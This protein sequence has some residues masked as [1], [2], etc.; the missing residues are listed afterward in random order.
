MLNLYIDYNFESANF[1]ILEDDS[2]TPSSRTKRQISDRVIGGRIV[3]GF[4]SVPNSFPWALFIRIF[5]TKV[6]EFTRKRMQ[7]KCGGSLLNKKFG[8]SAIHCFWK[9][10]V[11][12]IDINLDQPGRVRKWH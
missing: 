5:G 11:I 6:N 7:F 12:G 8:L 2:P 4:D 1:K 9:N 10:E 3:G